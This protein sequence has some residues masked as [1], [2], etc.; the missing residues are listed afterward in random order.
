MDRDTYEEEIEKA[1]EAGDLERMQELEKLEA[2]G[3]VG[4]DGAPLT[5]DDAFDREVDRARRSGDAERMKELERYEVNDEKHKALA[6]ADTQTRLD[7]A[8]SKAEE[9]G[10]A[11][12]ANLLRSVK[13]AEDTADAL[14]SALRTA[15]GYHYDAIRSILEG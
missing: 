5:V 14:Q 1:Q 11:E 4:D 2:E 8:L 6:D 3:R 13:E 10:N 9:E 12:L 15:T 7:V